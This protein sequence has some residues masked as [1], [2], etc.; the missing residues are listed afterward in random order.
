MC[1]QIIWMEKS[2][3]KWMDVSY[4]T[5]VMQVCPHEKLIYLYVVDEWHGWRLIQIVDPRISTWQVNMESFDRSRSL[6]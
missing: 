4:D 2:D 5:L 1:L 3:G 6:L